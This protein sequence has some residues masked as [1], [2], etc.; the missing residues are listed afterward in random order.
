MLHSITTE[1]ATADFQKKYNLN[2]TEYE[3]FM[4]AV[5]E[6]YAYGTAEVKSEVVLNVFSKFNVRIEN[7]KIFK[8]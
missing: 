3:Q 6:C 2:D 1:M 5:N 8:E 7:D 4:E